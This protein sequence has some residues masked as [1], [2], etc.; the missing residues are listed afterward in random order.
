M[1][2]TKPEISRVGG[3]R[4]SLSTRAL[5]RSPL[6]RQ[7]SFLLSPFSPLSQF[8]L[9]PFHSTASSP[10][11]SLPSSD[12]RRLPFPRIYLSPFAHLLLVAILLATATLVA[13]S[14][15]PMGALCG[16]REGRRW[17]ARRRPPLPLLSPPL[18]LSGRRQIHWLGGG[19]HWIW[20]A[21]R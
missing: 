12:A 21:W 19:G 15:S 14:L 2:H 9:P 1:I 11:T 17:R 6:S 4:A 7:I 5:T 3:T 8:C 10:T 13:L 20:P 18:L 16:G